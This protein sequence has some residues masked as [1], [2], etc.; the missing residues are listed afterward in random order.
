M[1][2]CWFREWPQTLE[3][4]LQ[5]LNN[6]INGRGSVRTFGGH[7]CVKGGTLRLTGCKWIPPSSPS[8][9]R[10]PHPSNALSRGGVASWLFS[11]CSFQRANSAYTWYNKR[12]R[13]LSTPGA[14]CP[15]SR[16]LH[17]LF[18]YACIVRFGP[19]C[20]V[21]LLHGL[22]AGVTHNFRPFG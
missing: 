18:I 10:P 1:C 19:D 6:T 5:G 20:C 21:C 17:S 2:R 11:P 22:M 8:L 7:I 9:V 15:A 4:Y 16:R 13:H 12:K 3:S 14:G